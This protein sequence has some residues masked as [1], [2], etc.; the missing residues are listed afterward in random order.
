VVVGLRSSGVVT[1]LFDEPGVFGTRQ[2]YIHCCGHLEQLYLLLYVVS[3]ECGDAV[4]SAA[5]THNPSCGSYMTQGL[6]EVR[7]VGFTTS[8]HLP[9]DLHLNQSYSLP[10][11]SGD[12]VLDGLWV[13]HKVLE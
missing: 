6:S 5:L 4:G 10:K 9:A 2:L 12:L 13:K 3:G 1:V 7:V 11:K 8:R